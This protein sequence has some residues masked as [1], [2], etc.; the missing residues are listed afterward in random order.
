MDKM[1]SVTAAYGSS[2]LISAIILLLGITKEKE[3]SVDCHAQKTY[4]QE[5][6]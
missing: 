4:I 5:Y 6:F 2:M 1:F 3:N